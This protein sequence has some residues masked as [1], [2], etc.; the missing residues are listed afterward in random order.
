MARKKR[1]TLK[2]PNLKKNIIGKAKKMFSNLSEC[3]LEY[4]VFID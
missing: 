3:V 2:K 4:F 1:L